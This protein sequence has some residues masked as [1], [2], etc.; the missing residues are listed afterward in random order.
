[1]RLVDTKD[2]YEDTAIN[3]KGQS[4]ENLLSKEP[5]IEIGKITTEIDSRKKTVRSE[6]AAI[7]NL[8]ADAMRNGADADIGRANG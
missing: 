5:D 1:M 4:Y 2:V 6:E 7:G 8:I 3:T